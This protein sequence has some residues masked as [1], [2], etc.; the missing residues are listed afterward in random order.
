LVCFLFFG[1]T[2]SLTKVSISLFM[3]AMPEIISSI[4]CILMVRFVL[5]VPVH[6]L[7]IFIPRFILDWVFFIDSIST[8]RS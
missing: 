1:I 8:F 4:S 3:I 5:K 7:K 6:D 2:F